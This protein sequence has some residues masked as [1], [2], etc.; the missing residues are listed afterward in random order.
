MSLVKGSLAIAG[1]VALAAGSAQAAPILLEDGNASTVFDPMSQSGQSQ[2]LVDGVHMLTHEWF[3]YRIGQNA[4]SSIDT[5]DAA[6]QVFHSD[7]N[8]FDDVRRDA[9]SVLYTSPGFLQIEATF[10]LRGGTAGSNTSDVTETLTIRN[11]GTV[12]LPIS[13]FQYADFDLNGTVFDDYVNITALNNVLQGD[14][15]VTV[16]ETIVNPPSSLFEANFFANTLAALND[17]VAT[18]LNG[19]AGAVNGDLTWAFQWDFLL[20]A[21]DSFTI[22]KDKLIVPTPGALAL[23]GVGGLALARR[24]RA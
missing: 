23:L 4:E 16:S 18:N 3:W 20:G 7:T 15:P 21:G 13:F 12:A 17:G 8:P 6:P 24:R 10:I 19:V 14:G 2:W 1:A 11:L 22:S 9:L 5:L